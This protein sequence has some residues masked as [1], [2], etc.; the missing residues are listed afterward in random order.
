MC[1]QINISGKSYIHCL[2]L[3]YECPPTAT[4]SALD[5]RNTIATTGSAYN[6][7]NT[8]ISPY[9]GLTLTSSPTH[10]CN[11]GVTLSGPGFGEK[12]SVH[13]WAQSRELHFICVYLFCGIFP[14]DIFFEFPHKCL[15]SP[16]PIPKRSN[17]ESPS[18]FNHR[19]TVAAGERFRPFAPAPPFHSGL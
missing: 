15:T 12:V 7:Q 18:P 4:S 6:T 16:P 8:E 1:S 14:T 19:S 13:R 3:Y 2:K 9:L 5:L 17:S 10:T 11:P